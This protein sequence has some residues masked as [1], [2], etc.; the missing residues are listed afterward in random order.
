MLA[1]AQSHQLHPATSADRAAIA[2]LRAIALPNK[3]KLRGVA[4]RPLFEGISAQVPAPEGVTFRAET[5]GGVAGWWCEPSGAQA[6]AVILHAHGGWFSW[7]S[8]EGF[9]HLVGHIARS[10]GARVRP[11]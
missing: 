3:G 9:R 10:S 6:D 4:A 2:Q 7:G 11:R 8:A 5:I 1:K